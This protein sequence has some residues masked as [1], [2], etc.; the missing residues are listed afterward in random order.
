MKIYRA[1]LNGDQVYYFLA[2]T[3]EEA[4][5]DAETFGQAVSAI[6]YVGLV[7]YRR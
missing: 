7:S 5:S 2:T 1:R 3:L 4:L 6:E